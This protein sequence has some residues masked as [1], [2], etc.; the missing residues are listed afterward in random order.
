MSGYHNGEYR[1]QLSRIEAHVSGLETTIVGAV[2]D[3][4]SAIDR[5]GNKVETL[6]SQLSEWRQM[7]QSFLPLKLVLILLSIVV[8]AFAGG[9]AFQ[10]L[11]LH[12]NLP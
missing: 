8:F 2:R 6:T 3:L 4:S 11:K 9:A 1:E 7:Q 12:L 5:L 10:T